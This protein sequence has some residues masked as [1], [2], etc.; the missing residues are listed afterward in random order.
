MDFALALRDKLESI[1]QE[2]FNQFVLRVGECLPD[3]L[4]YISQSVH[5]TKI[6]ISLFEGAFKLMKNGVYFIVMA[7]GC[8]VI[9]DFDLSKLVD[10]Q[11]HNVFR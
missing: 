3:M 5:D 2:C 11:R 8:Q 9:Q 10:L 6:F 1:N 4:E 7:L